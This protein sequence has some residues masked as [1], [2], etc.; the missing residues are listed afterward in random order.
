MEKNSYA[1]LISAAQDMRNAQKKYFL[2]AKKN[3]QDKKEALYE[4]KAKE[5]EFQVTLHTF[6][7]NNDRYNIEQYLGGGG[8]FTQFAQLC[9]EL[10][11]LQGKAFQA[12]KIQNYKDPII[13]ECREAE[14]NF[15]KHLDEA[16][17]A[18]NPIAKQAD[19]FG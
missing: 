8:N 17:Q 5:L 3:S 14:K 7:Q 15:D 11:D 9:Q 2:A 1:A 12:L 10:I 13:A 18:I 16:K 19:L 6:T 4:A